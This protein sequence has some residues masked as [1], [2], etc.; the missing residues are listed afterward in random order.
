MQQVINCASN[1]CC[2]FL[3][4][5]PW[6]DQPPSSISKGFAVHLAD[7]QICDHI[8]CASQIM[9]VFGTGTAAIVSQV[10]EIHYEGVHMSPSLIKP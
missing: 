9:E 1:F 2:V 10:S 8:V 6:Y 5:G 4:G 7:R 3:N